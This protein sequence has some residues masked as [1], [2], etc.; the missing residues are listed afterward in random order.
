[1]AIC[2]CHLKRRARRLQR[3]AKAQSLTN[4]PLPRAASRTSCNS[5]PRASA[6]APVAGSHWLP[7]SC[8][9]ECRGVRKPLASPLQSS[10]RKAVQIRAGRSLRRHVATPSR[11]R[12]C[13][14]LN[15]KKSF[16]GSF[17]ILEYAEQRTHGHS[18]QRVQK[19]CPKRYCPEQHVVAGPF[20]W[21]GA[22]VLLEGSLR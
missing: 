12:T 14:K 21:L 8:Q 5:S 1:M 3:K 18:Q 16:K 6:A 15:T 22:K 2:S 20:V 19:F 11:R 9:P 13:R 10:P 4:L 7:A 17:A